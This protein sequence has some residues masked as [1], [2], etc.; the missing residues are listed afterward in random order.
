MR[1]AFVTVADSMA[2]NDFCAA[3]WSLLKN[4]LFYIHDRRRKLQT[5]YA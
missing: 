5:F 3:R 1:N 4:L 2:R